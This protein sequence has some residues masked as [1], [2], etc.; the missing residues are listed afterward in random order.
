MSIT[1][2]A[3]FCGSSTGN[4]KIFAQHATEIGRLFAAN[5]ITLIYGGGNSGLMGIAANEVMAGNGKVIGIMPRLLTEWERQHTKITELL[6]VSDMHTR[7]RMLY[8]KSDAAIILPGGYGTMDEFFE[9]LTWNQ[10]KIHNKPIIILNSA[11]YYDHL[12]KHMAKMQNEKF[13]Y[14]PFAETV[15]VVTV[16]GEIEFLKS[17]TSGK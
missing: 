1:A 9:I 12:L 11:G 8:E 10:L 17:V 15:T 7:K 6:E 4:N 3:V 2:A 14:T 5:N 16:P 13:L